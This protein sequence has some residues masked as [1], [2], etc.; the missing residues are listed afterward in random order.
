[1]NTEKKGHPAGLY[2]VFFY[3]DVGTLQLLC[4]AWYF[5][6]LPNSLLAQWRAWV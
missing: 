4:D 2:L 1:M 5:S 3:R 6:S